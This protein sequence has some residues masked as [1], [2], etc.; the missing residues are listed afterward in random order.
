MRDQLEFIAPMMPTLVDFPPSS[1][2]WL[3]EVKFDG[4]RCQIIIQTSGVRIFTRRGQDWTEKLKVIADA[5]QNELRMDSA[6]IDG[7]LLYPHVSRL[8]DFHA[9]QAVIRSHSDEIVFSA[10][11]LLHLNGE[12]LRGEPVEERRDRLS[13]LLPVGGRI[14]FSDTLQGTPEQLFASV[15][16]RNQE[17]IVCKRPGSSYVSGVSHNWLKI[18]TFA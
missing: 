1:G 11:D 8:S 16:G 3:T 12:D 7:E 15:G 9:L 2:E 17:G 10:F 13:L 6:I 5:A 14:R 18:K 4:W